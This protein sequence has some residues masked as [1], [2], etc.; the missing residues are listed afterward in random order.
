MFENFLIL[1]GYDLDSCT[2]ARVFQA[3]SQH[4]QSDSREFDD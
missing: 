4:S 2:N 1:T 3:S